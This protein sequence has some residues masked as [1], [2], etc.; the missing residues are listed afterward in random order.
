MKTEKTRTRRMTRPVARVTNPTEDMAP[1]KAAPQK[2]AHALPA[3]RRYGPLAGLALAMAAAL[4]LGLP[5]ALSF[6]RLVDQRE[7]LR[8]WVDSHQVGAML[9]YALLYVAVVAL[10]LPGGLVLTIAGGFLFGWLAGG[11]LALGCATTGAML[12]F[13]IARSAAGDMLAAKAGPRM[14]ALASELKRDA[15]AYL[16]FLRLVPVFPFWLVN[17]AP[18]LVGVRAGTFLWTTALGILPGTFAFALAGAGLDAAV[19]AQDAAHAACLAGGRGDCVRQFNARALLAPE[20]LA[21]FVAM[22]LLAL[23]P[24]AAKRWR[25]R[26]VRATP[27]SEGAGPLDGGGGVA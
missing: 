13:R 15:A 8:G 23:L 26:R 9:G 3:W 19:A 18:A 17:L 2:A 14:A 11:L 10:S 4:A 21:A 22:G 25:A 20:I 12:V 16:L 6:D 27:S 7:A 24:I 5:E 1:H